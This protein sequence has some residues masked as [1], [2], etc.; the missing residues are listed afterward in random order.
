VLADDGFS[1]GVLYRGDRAA[2]APPLKPSIAVADIE[3]E[4][5]LA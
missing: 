2:V 1:L 3:R 4:F 5:T